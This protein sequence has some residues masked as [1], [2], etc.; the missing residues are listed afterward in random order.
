M[1][2]RR[3]THLTEADLHRLRAALVKKRDE[4]IAA[5]RSTTAEQR[6]IHD[7]ETEQGDIAENLIEQEASLRIGAFDATLLSDVERA[8]KKLDEGD[9]GRSEDSGSPIP[10]ARLEAVPWAR[11]TAQEEQATRRAR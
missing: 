6:G 5:Q 7:P 2:E 11:R 1:P 10:L 4:L 3:A 8:L 9:Y